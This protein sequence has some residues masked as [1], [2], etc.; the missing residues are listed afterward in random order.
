MLDAH[1]RFELDAWSGDGLARS[2]AEEVGAAFA[3][4]GSVRL[5]EV[6]TADQMVGW[7]T[8]LLSA[9]PSDEVWGLLTD[10]A[11]VVHETLL[12][13]DVTVVADLVPREVYDG[14][15][16]AA[17]AARDVRP[18][19]VEQ[20]TSSE[21]YAELISY[22]LY[23]G[24]KNYVLT[25]NVMARRIPGASSLLKF[26]QNAINSAA[27]GLEK[28]VDKQ[29]TA[30]INANV[31]DT[32]SGSSDF[33]T[34]V[35]DDDMIRTIAGEI[36]SVNADG[37]VADAAALVDERTVDGAADAARALWLHLGSTPL[38][39]DLAGL[40]VDELFAR[41]E[42][43][44]IADLLAGAGIEPE[45]VVAELAQ[46]LG[47]LAGQARGSGYLETRIRA[48]LEAFYDSYDPPDPADR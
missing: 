2:V 33:L 17:A 27:P 30:F 1:V 7:V 31:Q 36:W 38:V 46:A 16:D 11:A 15:V 41:C 3:W 40:V 47:A 26:G 14:V 22:V 10:L 4:L 24:L 23:Q 5:E 21:V 45:A 8:R 48:R 13:E 39:R 29:L 42:D 6:V 44:S 32:I 43:R 20:I 9:P 19:I 28:A 18:V 35:L 12:E 25:E 37:T 34:S